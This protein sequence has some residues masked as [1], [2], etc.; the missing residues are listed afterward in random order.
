[1]KLDDG[2]RRWVEEGPGVV[3]LSLLGEASLLH[4]RDRP[5][6]LVEH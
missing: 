1:M 5:G 4:Q 6:P 2:T 3:G